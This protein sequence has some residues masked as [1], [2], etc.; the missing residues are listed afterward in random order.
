MA[1]TAPKFSNNTN[2]PFF[3]ELRKRVHEYFKENG[4]DQRANY[5][6]GIKTAL[7]LALYFVPYFLMIADIL[8]YWGMILCAMGMGFGYAGLG[9]SV[10][11][12]AA[13]GA[14]FKNQRLNNLFSYSMN[15]LGGNKYNWTVQHNIKHHTYTN[16]YG[17]DDDIEVGGLIRLSKE[18]KKLKA[19]RFQHFYAWFVYGMAT[20]FWVTVKDFKQFN[21]YY[22]AK[23]PKRR[24][25]AAE[26]STLLLS[27][28]FYYGYIIVLPL[29]L[30]TSIAW[31]Q[32]L[33]LFGIMH[34]VS[35]VVLSTIFQLA[36]VV[37]NAEGVTANEDGIVES[38]FAEHQMKTTVDFAR[39]SK[40]LTWY[41]GGL[42]FQVEHHLFPTICH[43]HYK[44]L[45]EIVRNTA[46]EFG[47]KYRENRTL[48]N[49]LS[50]HYRALKALGARA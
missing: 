49:A 38:S 6:M 43:V 17:H 3:P 4:I 13:H 44:E 20:L 41:V 18:D 29:I 31:W 7:L 30:I 34:F 19:H 15:M 26:V 8:P 33:I 1:I 23:G 46:E 28:V 48:G 45:S 35:G 47:V 32:Y 21:G 12:D 10:M 11:H 25:K 22:D 27:K 37:D 39:H 42:N 16:I 14:Y 9:M 40:F 2:S 5:K 50:S 36:H 24:S